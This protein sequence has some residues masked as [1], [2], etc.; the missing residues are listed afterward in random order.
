MITVCTVSLFI[1]FLKY[2]ESRCGNNFFKGTVGKSQFPDALLRQHGEYAELCIGLHSPHMT[3]SSQTQS[4]A[5]THG[6]GMVLVAHRAGIGEQSHKRFGIFG[7]QAAKLDSVHFF[8]CK[9]IGLFAGH[10][11]ELFFFFSGQDNG[12][13]GPFRLLSGTGVYIQRSILMEL[14]QKILKLHDAFQIPF[15]WL[16]NTSIACSRRLSNKYI[17]KRS[18]IYSY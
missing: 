9:C 6:E 3:G 5:K 4:V 18:H 14:I 15:L 8:A 1:S 7:G 13:A 2:A 17:T 12:A 10:G 11:Q 16:L